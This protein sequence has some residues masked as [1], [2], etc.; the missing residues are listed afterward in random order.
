[1][2]VCVCVLVSMDRA[3]RF[4]IKQS[5]AFSGKTCIFF[6][7]LVCVC[8]WMCVCMCV[9]ML[10]FCTL[11]FEEETEEVDLPGPYG[12]QWVARTCAGQLRP[13]LC[14]ARE[15]PSFLPDNEESTDVVT[16]MHKMFPVPRGRS[17]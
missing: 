6:L 10:F 7:F 9:P 17:K 15:P 4:T 8:V 3:I 14:W 16:C 11:L 1:M 12:V 2:Y 13:F 5:S